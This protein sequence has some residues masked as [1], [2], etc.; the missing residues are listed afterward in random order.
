MNFIFLLQPV[1]SRSV[2]TFRDK[3]GT[4]LFVIVNNGECLGLCLDT[5]QAMD[6]ISEKYYYVDPKNDSSVGEYLD[7]IGAKFQK[8][9]PILFYK[10]KIA[11]NPT[12]NKGIINFLDL[13]RRINK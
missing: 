1:L 10:T 9:Q 6:L 13:A 4:G 12:Q 11:L 8:G 3:V 2:R 7:K 5:K